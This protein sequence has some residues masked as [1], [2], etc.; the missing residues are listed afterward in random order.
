MAAAIGLAGIPLRV[1]ITDG[2]ELI[3][4]QV[5]VLYCSLM[6]HR[7]TSARALDRFESAVLLLLRRLFLLLRVVGRQQ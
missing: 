2:S 6:L 5:P 7:V 3:R 4:T 1:R